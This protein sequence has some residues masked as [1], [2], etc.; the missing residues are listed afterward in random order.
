MTT[1]LDLKTA[2]SHMLPFEYNENHWTVRVAAFVE[3]VR[4]EMR[5][6]KAKA[7]L[8]KYPDHLLRDIGL[9]RHMLG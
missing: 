7:E 2:G 6:E 1:Y 9:D 3:R 8:R 5:H 4:T